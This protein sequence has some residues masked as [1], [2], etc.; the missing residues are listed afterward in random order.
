MYMHVLHS[1]SSQSNPATLSL[2]QLVWVQLI[3]VSIV[4]RER[5]NFDTFQ[6]VTLSYVD[7]LVAHVQGSRLVYIADSFCLYYWIKRIQRMQI[8]PSLAIQIL[9]SRAALRTNILGP[10]FVFT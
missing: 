5:L 10:I 2:R 8:R 4:V 3:Y 1:L 7:W 6:I 9:D